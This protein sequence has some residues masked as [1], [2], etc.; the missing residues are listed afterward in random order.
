LSFSGMYTYVLHNEG[1]TPQGIYVVHVYFIPP[2]GAEK[3]AFSNIETVSSLK[4]YKYYSPMRLIAVTYFSISERT[5]SL[6]SVL[7]FSRAV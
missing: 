4:T 3:E 7:I 2:I 5:E 6:V 1:S